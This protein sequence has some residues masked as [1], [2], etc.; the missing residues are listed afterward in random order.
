LQQT[1]KFSWPCIQLFQLFVPALNGSFFQAGE[2]PFFFESCFLIVFQQTAGCASIKNGLYFLQSIDS[3]AVPVVSVELQVKCI[4]GILI[5][6][7]F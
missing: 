1:P 7:I 3:G 4:S 5:Q 2:H 6:K